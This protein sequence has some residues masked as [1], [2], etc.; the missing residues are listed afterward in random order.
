MLSLSG[1][2]LML[3]GGTLCHESPMSCQQ[4]MTNRW[5]WQTTADET[6]IPPVCIT[7]DVTP[8]RFSR[9][10]K[11]VRLRSEVGMNPSRGAPSLSATPEWGL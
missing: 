11:M 3:I 1:F 9:G 10:G 8:L 4:S 6:Q 5:E 7:S 2:V